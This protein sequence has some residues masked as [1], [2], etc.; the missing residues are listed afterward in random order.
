MNG[1]SVLDRFLQTD[2][3]CLAIRF[4]VVA[5][6]ST[7]SATTETPRSTRRSRERGYA[8]SW[9]LQYGHHDPR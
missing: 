1:R 2:P 7:D 8:L 9:A 4:C 5:S 3:P 6:S